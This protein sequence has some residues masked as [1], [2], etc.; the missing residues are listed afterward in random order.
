[1]SSLV[2]QLVHCYLSNR[3]YGQYIE[4]KQT[5][6]SGSRQKQ[7]LDPSRRTKERIVTVVKQDI[8][9][10]GKVVKYAR[11]RSDAKDVS[12]NFV[13]FDQRNLYT[14]LQ[15]SDRSKYCGRIICQA[16]TNVLLANF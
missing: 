5:M 3:T 4:S 11:Q 6:S 1:M 10:I 13:T 7:A 2:D 15:Y 8:E 9:E 16:V 12:G 14:T